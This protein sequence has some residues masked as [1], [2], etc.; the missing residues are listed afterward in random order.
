M[1]FSDI[2]SHIIYQ[3]TQIWV[4]DSLAITYF[5]RVG[6]FADELRNFHDDLD[7]CANFTITSCSHCYVTV[8]IICPDN[9]WLVK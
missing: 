5:A 1:S 8:K 6:K 9:G 2:L 3:A 4:R 7:S